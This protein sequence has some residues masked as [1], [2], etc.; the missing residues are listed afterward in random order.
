MIFHHA[1]RSAG[2]N[3]GQSLWAMS[4]LL[5]ADGSWRS[6]VVKASP[7]T[8]IQ[9]GPALL[10]LLPNSN[11]KPSSE[12]CLCGNLRQTASENN[13]WNSGDQKTCFTCCIFFFYS[14]WVLS[15]KFLRQNAVL[16][17]KR[18]SHVANCVYK[19]LQCTWCL[20][21]LQMRSQY[22]AKH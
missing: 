1:A 8:H 4:W 10:L 9:Q 12:G 15:Y 13:S 14:A 2:E 16:G 5:S 20:L 18:D 7:E 22:A 3:V 6:A 17:I 11:T 21:K 19:K